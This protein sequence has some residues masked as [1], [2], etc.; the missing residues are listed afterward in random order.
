V[1][2]EDGCVVCEVVS[3]EREAP[4]GAVYK[5]EFWTV[6]HRLEP[7]LLRGYLVVKLSRHCESLSE[8]TPGEAAALGPVVQRVCSALSRVVGAE[9]V[10]VC[11]WGDGVKHVHFHVI[12]RVAG[13]PAGNLTVSVLLRAKHILYRLGVKRFVPGGGEVAAVAAGLREE[14]GGRS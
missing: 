9:K 11:C 1:P 6:T 13:M 12:P 14:L 7:V 10:Y 2:T 5:D 3:G 4:G 8:L